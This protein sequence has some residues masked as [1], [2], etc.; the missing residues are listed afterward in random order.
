LDSAV[1]CGLAQKVADELLTL[2]DIT[3]EFGTL[4]YVDPP[5]ADRALA[6]SSMIKMAEQVIP[7]V[8]AETTVKLR[9]LERT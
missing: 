1:I 2:R 8:G 3:G 4:L 9:T 5:S 7:L 6:H